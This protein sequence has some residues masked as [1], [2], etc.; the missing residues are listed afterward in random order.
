MK[1]LLSILL[2]LMLLA[3]ALPALAETA[4]AEPVKIT[5][6]HTN[7]VHGRYDYTT[8]MGYA[9]VA[10]YINEARNAGENVL[11]LDAGDTTHGTIFA[12]ATKGESII[13]I[14]NE[15]GYAAMTPGN[16]DFNYGKDHLL[17]LAGMANFPML[18]STLKNEDGSYL[19]TPYTIVEVAGKQIAIVGAEN[20]HMKSVIHPSHIDGLT[21]DTVDAV[22]LAVEEVK[23]KS[24]A[25]IVLA[26]WGSGDEYLPDSAELSK[27]PGIDLVI[28]GHSHTL[29]NDIVQV[30]GGAPVTSTGEY[31]NNLGKV[32]LEFTDDGVKAE[33]VLIPNPKRFEDHKIL[34]LVS[35]IEGSQ[36]AILDTVIGKTD[37]D[38]IGERAIVRTQETNLGDYVCDVLIELSGAEVALFNG[39]GI[40][41]TVP[42]G[43]I[44]IRD[45]NEVFPFGNYVVQISVTGEQIVQAL[46]HGYRL[47]PESNGGFAQIGG[48]TC[49]VDPSKEVG[50]RVSDVKV[51][52]A[53]ID[54]AKSYV[55][56]TNDFLAAGGDGYEMLKGA[57]MLLQMSVMDDMLMDKI[58]QAGTIAPEPD[59]RITV[60]G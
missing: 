52:G 46:E 51:Q 31:L 39:G 56:V 55:M 42:A 19:L 59:G 30:E 35:D 37:V 2:A 27:I 18:S 9:M 8:G 24:D 58:Q 11:V 41:K 1:K 17:E 60:V 38:L 29:L 48:I 23:D 57:P 5:V 13:A 4:P 32:V 14:M 22:K 40:R 12:N 43:D 20:P 3:S 6:F 53:E 49:T 10:S 36:S 50:S 33:T 7:D 15:I 21:F 34:N 28:D 45:I 44:T 47:M 26:H 16:H 25:V 54:L